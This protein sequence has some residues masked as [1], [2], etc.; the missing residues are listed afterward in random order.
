MRALVVAVAQLVSPPLFYEGAVLLTCSLPIRLCSSVPGGSLG[1]KALQ[2]KQSALSAVRDLR[3]HWF[4][5]HSGSPVPSPP[6]WS[7]EPRLSAARV[8]ANAA[9]PVRGTAGANLEILEEE[10]AGTIPVGCIVIRGGGEAVSQ[11]AVAVEGLL[12]YSDARLAR[13]YSTQA[14]RAASAVPETWWVPSFFHPA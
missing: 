4:P 14:R 10:T 12:A 2:S 6:P 11:A 7:S 5:L 9:T 13:Q 3:R 8:T 1:K